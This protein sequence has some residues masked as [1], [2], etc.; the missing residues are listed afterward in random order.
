ML[1]KKPPNSKKRVLLN[2]FLIIMIDVVISLLIP[3]GEDEGE[4]LD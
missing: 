4:D 2:L 1:E 3:I